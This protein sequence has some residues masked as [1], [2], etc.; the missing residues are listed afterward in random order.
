MKD[1]R[2]CH[3]LDQGAIRVRGGGVAGAIA[4]V[5]VTRLRIIPCVKQSLMSPQ[6]FIHLS[7]FLNRA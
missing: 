6:Y 2:L 4:G 5:D 3:S 7:P 1:G